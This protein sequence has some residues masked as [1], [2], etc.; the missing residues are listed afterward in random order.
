MEQTLEIKFSKEELQ[1]AA[2]IIAKEVTD[3][4]FYELLMLRY[5]PEINLIK[6]G[7]IKAL[8]NEEIDSFLRERINACK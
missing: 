2:K 4:M 3:R 7:K 8:R 1:K 5:I 6:K